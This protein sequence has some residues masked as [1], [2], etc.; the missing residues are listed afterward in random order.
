MAWSSRLGVQWPL[1]FSNRD[2]MCEDG[3][4]QRLANRRQHGVRI[5][6]PVLVPDVASYP[7]ERFRTYA[8]LF[9]N[10][11]VWNCL[12][13]SMSNENRTSA[14]VEGETLSYQRDGE[15]SQLRVG[16]PAWYA[17]L[18]TATSFRV[19]SPF[20]TFTVRREQA[21]NKRGDWYW[22]AYRK[23]E[24]KL[25][26]F[27]VGPAEEVTFERLN[28]VAAR[29]SAQDTIT[30][31][32]PEPPQSVPQGHA[33]RPA[34]GA[35][36]QLDEGARASEIVKR[37]TS[38]LPL[39]LTSLIGREREIA[40]ISTLLGRPE[41]RLLTLSGTG[42]VGKTRLALAI[43]TELRDAFPDGIGFVSLVSLH[44]A[45]LVLPAIA[46]AEGLQGISTRPPLELLSAS[47]RE[48][49]RLLVLDNF[50]TV[51][52]AAPS[53]VDLLAACPRLKLL[54]TSREVLRVRG[55]RE[56]VVQPLALPDPQHLPDD[57][58]LAHYGAVALFLER[59]REVQPT[60]QLTASTAPLITEICRRLD[61]LPLAL[62]L[63]AAR[64]KLLP[65]QALLERLEHRLAV[66]TG[67]PRDLPARQQTLRNTLAWSYSLLPVEEQR[68]FR[69]LSVFV[70]GCRLEAVEHLS[71]ALGDEQAQVLDGVT[72]LLDKH[73]IYRAEQDTNGARFHLLETIR[74]YGLEVLEADGELEAVRLAHAQYY[75]T[76]AEEADAHLFTREQQRWLE[77]LKQEHD[78]LR[79]VM[80]W[81]VEQGEDRQ[82]RDIA[83]RLAGALRSFWIDYG[84]VYEGQQFVER[85]LGRREGITAP[86][87]AKALHAAGRL[88][89]VQGEYRRAEVLC[90]ESLALYRELHGPR[91]MAS[92]LELLGW[93]ATWLGDAPRATT[94]LEGSLALSRSAG[95]TVR[96]A[97]AL[98]PLALM[99]LTQAGHDDAPR[100][101]SLLEES[102]LLFREERVQAG[103]ARSLYG[104]GL[105][106]FQQGDAARARALFEESFALFSA[107]GQR[108]WATQPLYRLGKVAAQVGDLP[109]AY[110]FYQESLAL[111]QE[112]DDQQS[113]A[114]CLEA[115]GAVVARQGHAVWAAQ[116]WGAA[117]ALRA[118]GGPS[119]LPQILALTLPGERAD[120]ERMRAWV[121]AQ[122]GEQAFAQALAEG[123][124]MTPE[125]ALAAGQHTLPAS[126]P[127]APA[128]ADRPQV[129]S[130]AS[131]NDLTEREVEVLRLVA[132]GLSDAQVAEILVISPRTVN[133]HLRSIY[134]KLGITSR[135]AATLFAI[136]QQ[137]I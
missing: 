19:R 17:W 36:R 113:S 125:Q 56:F 114:A 27:Y 53:L 55:E 115:W 136:K 2:K 75:L 37:P 54:V 7:D 107:L 90:Q 73:L 62:E 20:G 14:L 13:M 91:E 46:Q 109:A 5:V 34:T 137:L 35:V 80:Q 76:L 26:R 135:H 110:A 72:S 116:L 3:L 22:R 1:V 123:R 95:D 102:L 52:A 10:R 82:R 97:Y 67:G 39:P 42:G 44:D 45:D 74:E 59:A 127:N 121:R 48:R 112:L 23:R 49:H 66:L 131:P 21:G 38:T 31:E 83:W 64:L 41:V 126:P 81:S 58:T 129:P 12:G 101:R 99:L 84:Y 133:A 9:W 57:E 108:L 32:E 122:L 11:C 33:H 85:A 117:Q 93:I 134:S 103:I 118:A 40:A 92:V 25:H 77:Q 4:Q 18:R 100:V 86:V 70:D 79:A 130:P 63:A 16:T 78:N 61:G 96:L 51:V 104:L 65:L 106:H 105:W 8:I 98:I 132:R 68:L 47:L 89:L 119:Y 24:G 94:L 30:G 128:R 60:L 15:R 87:R 43:A 28:T 88:A 50:E 6:L 120:D 111:F 29:L 71:H 69:S 124:A